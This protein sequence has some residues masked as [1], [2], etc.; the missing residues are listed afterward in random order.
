[1][2][3]KLFLGGNWGGFPFLLLLLFVAGCQKDNSIANQK[4][5]NTI[6]LDVYS[7]TTAEDKCSYYLSPSAG[8][9]YV[10]EKYIDLCKADL[11]VKVLRED[12]WQLGF[13]IKASVKVFIIK[14]DSYSPVEKPNLN[15]L[16]V[17]ANY[18]CNGVKPSRDVCENSGTRSAH[19]QDSGYRFCIPIQFSNCQ[20]LYKTVGIGTAYSGL[21]CTGSIIGSSPIKAWVC[22]KL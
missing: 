15:D 4:K 19:I 10:A 14:E 8:K 5:S 2:K 13:P 6:P 17:R 9:L 12:L 22:G 7:S 1:M 16:R 20:E 3:K 21:N 11:D 18:A